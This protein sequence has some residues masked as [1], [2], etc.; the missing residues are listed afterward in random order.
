MV[1]EGSLVVRIPEFQ[2]SFEFDYRSH[3]L[4]KVLK[5]KRYEPDLVRLIY[6][7]IDPD[8]DV[9]DVGANIGLYTVLFSKLISDNRKVLAIEPAPLALKF[10]HKNIKRNNTT[11]TVIVFEGVAADAVGEYQLNVISGMEEYSSLGDIVHSSVRGKPYRPISVKGDTIDDLV[12]RFNL[13]P[14]FIKVDAEGAEHIVFDG[15]INSIGKYRPVILTELSDTLLSSFGTTSEVVIDQ[16][17]ANG[18]NIIDVAHP[19][20]SIKIPFAGRILAIP[21]AGNQ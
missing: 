9:I 5:T 17:R 1:E 19:E 12:D 15:A 16:L 13:N 20:A 7:Y 10:L 4:A 11:E 18:Y 14:G 21:I 3:I 8:R 6:E 2:G